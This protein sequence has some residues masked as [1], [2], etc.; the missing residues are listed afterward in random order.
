MAARTYD[1]MDAV[2]SAGA[3]DAKPAESAENIGSYT[4]VLT[5]VSKLAEPRYY[6]PPFKAGPY[7]WNV[8][9]LPPT[10][11]K[12]YLGVFVAV[13][14][15]KTLPV[16]W[17]RC[18]EFQVRVP[19]ALDPA[20]DKTNKSRHRFTQYTDTWGWRT[21]LEQADLKDGF[22]FCVNDTITI[23]CQVN[24]IPDDDFVDGTSWNSKKETGF[25]GILNQGSTCYMNSLLQSL[26][27]NPEFRRAVLMMPTED[28][29]DASASVPLALQRFFYR[30]QFGDQSATTAEL[31]KSFGWG[32]ADRFTE[33]DVQ[34]LNRVLIDN[35]DTKMK[36]SPAEGAID[37]MFQGKIANVIKCLHVDHEIR[38]PEL[39]YDLS[40][41]VKGCKSVYESLDKYCAAQMLTGANQFDA[42]ERGMQDASMGA[43][44]DSFPP[45]LNLLLKRF[46]YDFQQDRMVKVNDF[47]EFP[48]TLE[49][50]NYLSP[51]AERRVPQRYILHSVLVHSGGTSY[52]VMHGHYVAFVRAKAGKWFKFDDEKVTETKAKS[53]VEDNY[54]GDEIVQSMYYGSRTTYK[55]EKTYSAYMLVYIRESD[56]E[57]VLRPVSDEEVPKHLHTRF[58]EEKQEE[59]RE[60]KERAEAHLYCQV[61]LVQES[62]MARYCGVGLADLTVCDQVRVKKEATLADLHR[63]AADKLNVEP[64]RLR[65]WNWA[66]RTPL[67]SSR[68]GSVFTPDDDSMSISTLFQHG[69]TGQVLVD[70]I[71]PGGAFEPIAP[72]SRRV[73]FKLYNPADSTLKFLGSRCL[74]GGTKVAG[75]LDLGVQLGALDGPVELLWE[76]PTGT[77]A[78]QPD[79]PLSLVDHHI[80]DGDII[81]LQKPAD[82]SARFPTCGQFLEFLATR[83]MITCKPLGNYRD[84]KLWTKLELTM[85]TP[86]DDVACALAEALTAAD[87]KRAAD[88]QKEPPKEGAEPPKP[89]QVFDASYMRFTGHMTYY[90]QPR[91]ISMK[92]A[93]A[94]TLKDMLSSYYQSNTADIL[95]Y[96]ILDVPMAALDTNQQVKIHW[97]E[98]NVVVKEFKLLVPKKCTVKDVLDALRGHVQLQSTQQLRMFEVWDKKIYKNMPLSEEFHTYGDYS[99]WHCEEIPADELTIG[100][101]HSL[102][103]VAHYSKSQSSYSAL[104]HFGTPFYMLVGDREYG[105]DIKARVKEQLKVSDADWAQW[106]VSIVYAG[107]ARTLKDD[108]KMNL[109]QF[110]QFGDYIG[111]EHASTEPKIQ[112]NHDSTPLRIYN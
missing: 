71:P 39:Y 38:M 14:E 57:W 22:G 108:D 65:M 28:V 1:A 107:Q 45:V 88:A 67:T 82:R 70:I 73:F 31:T 27:H 68:P 84:E 4:W 3:A 40:L 16:G 63:A 49:L 9:V 64:E 79:S 86:Y 60:R 89:P 13:E 15:S 42:K 5:N 72:G 102:A 47:Y 35:L 43:Q 78:L 36:G 23:E 37:K 2:L 51:R 20:E 21:L 10:R 41:D 30:M 25:V 18:C 33:H 99:A 105:R 66:T 112:R 96:E 100:A 83:V 91:T 29:K 58:A 87:A 104:T 6:S 85:K 53:A 19:N 76:H 69:S 12:P 17:R 54:G 26:Y 90:D 94:P 50:D 61:Q 8:L 74:P 92:R 95:Y 52:Y 55:T 24:Y 110:T 46:T 77:R 111:L 109:F 93:E 106:K 62:D 34:E 11:D 59:A 103:R 75:L 101:D 97:R 44:F 32:S 81:V 98:N 56:L 7:D 48:E 80:C